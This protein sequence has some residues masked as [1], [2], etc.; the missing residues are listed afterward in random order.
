MGSAAMR[1]DGQ[2]GRARGNVEARSGRTALSLDDPSTSPATGDRAPHRAPGR[3]GVPPAE[4]ARAIALGRAVRVAAALSATL[5][6]GY[7]VAWVLGAAA[8]W[9]AA[10]VLTMKANMSLALVLAGAALLLLEGDAPPS[11]GRRALATALGAV[12]LATGALTL[13]EHAL[14]WDLGIDQLLAVEAPGAVGTASP[15]RIGPPGSLS[16]LLLGAGLVLSARRPSLAVYP[17]LATCVLVVVPAIGFLY[18]VSP[19]YASLATAIAWP[20]VIALFA[21][22]LGLVLSPRAEGP[23]AVLRRDDPG[24]ALLR[25]ALVPSVLL[26]LVLGYLRVQGERY[27]LYGTATGTALYAVT[28]VLLLSVLLWVI[29]RRLGAEVAARQ[30]QL[31]TERELAEWLASFPARNPIPI[32]E[33]DVDGRVRYA[34]AAAERLVPGIR[35][36][37]AGSHPWL[38]GWPDVVAAFLERAAPSVERTAAVGERTFQQMAYY[39][40][41]TGCVRIYGI[42]VTERSRAE[43]ALRESEEHLRAH[44]TELVGAQEALRE[45][46]RRKDEFLGMLSHELRNPLAPIRNSIFVLE[47]AA[48]GSEQAVK[49]RTVIKRQAE[50]LS[51]LVDDLLDVTRIARGKIELHR[52][53]VDLRQ[54]ASLAA[55]DFRHLLVE[56]GVELRTALPDEALWVEA[57]ATRVTQAIGNLLHNAAKF[58]RSGGE[59]TLSLRD[60]GPHV[61]LAVRDTGV[62]L[63]P[64]LLAH[65]FD[66][67]FQGHGTI[68]RTDGGLGLGL[69]VVKAVA[70]LHGGSVRAES[71]GAGAG[72]TFVLRIP[73]GAPLPAV[74]AAPPAPA[75]PARR[76]R[77]LVVDDNRDAAESLAQI[78]ALLGHEAAVAFDGPSAIESARAGGYDTVLCDIGLPG[79]SGY[80][81]A[82]ALRASHGAGL[83]LIAVTGYAQPEDVQRA[84]GA[85]F[86]GHLVKPAELSVIERW[87]A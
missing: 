30:A 58:T 47:R 29:A 25:R 79:M 39:V 5:G 19:F 12:V 54:V 28:L 10:G 43:V 77:V 64:S 32:V 69:A 17:G 7:L 26:V 21:L 9:S 24:G 72:A 70:E 18:G 20:T 83:R 31:E 35:S 46:A 81:L 22:G 66:P 13:G 52:T 50:H 59:V 3:D 40:P 6:G 55:E 23:L 53:R 73:R 45:T 78:V 67:F 33:V 63:D 84:A 80:E 11:R 82:Q 68:A 8:R 60:A 75:P 86:D 41:E 4:R 14:G 61:E 27:G 2:P 87:L 57:D 38:A 76:R 44:V 42:D 56:R 36:G 85:G 49:A 71:P 15:N 74:E 51:R 34:N 62:G 1:E 16:L 65:V 48:A 37:G